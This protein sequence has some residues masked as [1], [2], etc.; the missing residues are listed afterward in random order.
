MEVVHCDDEALPFA[1]ATFNLVLNRHSA[2]TPADVARVLKPGGTLLTEQVW[3][4]WRELKRFFPR[5][6]E[7]R[8]IETAYQEGLIA[9]GMTIVDARGHVVPAAFDHLGD[10]VF[11]LCVTPWT[12]PDFDPLGADLTTL[13]QVEQELT[14]PDGLVLS[15][16]AYLIE[17]QKPA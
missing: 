4:H 17:M 12:I 7:Y 3:E 1:D 14:T 9:S 10:L 2:L 11:M 13:V 5:M 15:D 8:G 16:G 6:V